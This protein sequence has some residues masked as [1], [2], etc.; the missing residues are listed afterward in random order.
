MSL[1]HTER[2]P[3]VDQRVAD[4]RDEERDGVRDLCVRT[5]PQQQIQDRVGDRAAHTDHSERDELGQKGTIE[6]SHRP[7]D[8]QGSLELH[9]SNATRRRI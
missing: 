9:E 6:A 1:A 3:P 5:R 4:R 7:D 8:A 2:E